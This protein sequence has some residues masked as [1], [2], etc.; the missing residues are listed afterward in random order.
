M[1][2]CTV[3]VVPPPIAIPVAVLVTTM[4]GVECSNQRHPM[5]W[6][7]THGHL[8]C[9]PTRSKCSW[10]PRR[11]NSSQDSWTALAIL[12]QWAVINGWSF[13]IYLVFW[14]IYFASSVCSIIASAVVYSLVVLKFRHRGNVWTQTNLVNWK[15]DGRSYWHEWFLYIALEFDGNSFSTSNAI[16]KP[17]CN[18]IFDRHLVIWDRFLLKIAPSPTPMFFIGVLFMAELGSKLQRPFA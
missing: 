1:V 15:V 10:D 13:G 11:D 3:S 8:I 7:K 9:H 14:C 12:Q 4:G 6:W 18:L 16:T 17:F 2:Q 5:L